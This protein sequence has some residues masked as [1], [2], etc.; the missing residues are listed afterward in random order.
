MWVNDL[1]LQWPLYMIYNSSWMSGVHYDCESYLYS[2]Y[3]RSLGSMKTMYSDY[4]AKNHFLWITT[5]STFPL[6]SICWSWM[7]LY[8]LVNVDFVKIFPVGPGWYMTAGGLLWI[9]LLRGLDLLRLLL[10]AYSGAMSNPVAPDS[11]R[12]HIAETTCSAWPIQGN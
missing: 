6:F 8:I 1:W 12:S 3:A 11:V 4:L 7:T 2:I 5:I 10:W 9:R